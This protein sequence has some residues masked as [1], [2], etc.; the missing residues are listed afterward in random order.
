MYNEELLDH[1]KYP[2]NKKKLESPC[3]AFDKDNPSCGDQIAIE[4]I[5]VNNVVSDLG[6]NGK[7]CVISQATA[8]ILTAA[9]IN[10]SVEDV[11]ALSA[12]DIT[13]LIQIS[14]GPNRLKCALLSLEV[15]QKGIINYQSSQKKD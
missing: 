8:S 7:G 4:G 5:I 6:F 11:L 12:D 15:L 9:C 3:F 10:K 13:K 2:C 14:L 1:F